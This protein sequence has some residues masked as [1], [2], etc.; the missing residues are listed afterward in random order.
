M[1]T[2]T[3]GW[4]YD[5]DRKEGDN[6]KTRQN[7]RLFNDHQKLSVNVTCFFWVDNDMPTEFP[8]RKVRPVACFA[9]LQFK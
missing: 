2:G 3:F 5:Y 4:S 7:I 9:I 8:Q 6:D 1:I